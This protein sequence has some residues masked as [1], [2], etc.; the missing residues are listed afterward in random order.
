[1]NNDAH[2]RFVDSHAECIGGYH[3]PALTGQ[4]TFLTLV[5]HFIGQS[6][7]I[8][9]SCYLV[10]RQKFGYFTGTF[11]VTGIYDG[12]TWYLIQYMQN[13][14]LFTF[15]VSD[16]IC[17]ILPFKTHAENLAPFFERESF[18]DVLDYFGGCCGGQ[19]QYRDIREHFSDVGN[20]Q[21]CGSEVV[22]PL[23]DAMR[24]VY[25]N[26]ADFHVFQLGLEDFCIESFGGYVQ[27]FVVSEDTVLQSYDNLFTSHAGIDGQCLDASFAKVA[28]LVFHQGNQGSDDDAEPFLCQC[29]N[30][31]GNGFPSSGRHK[32]Q[33]VMPFPDAVDD[34]F[35]YAA[36]RVVPP[37]FLQYLVVCHRMK[38][39]SLCRGGKLL[40][41][42][43]WFDVF[44]LQL[45]LAPFMGVFFD[46]VTD[47]ERALGFDVT[48]L[49]TLS[50][51]N[52]V[53]DVV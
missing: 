39:P 2:V 12:R 9:C 22:P 52:T 10:F 3:D 50:E 15:R 51:C 35:L 26:H 38:I 45:Y 47:V 6:C 43:T 46:G 17:Q 49:R 8:E 29:R 40:F 33:G 13:L 44:N 53:H 11:P 20:V 19:C 18:L 5:F 4:P 31:E 1:M 16:N 14:F 48:G 30:L 34:I 25:G 27:E 23:G 21:V 42:F 7:M 32:S 41:F 24:F 28:Y 37:I 36:E